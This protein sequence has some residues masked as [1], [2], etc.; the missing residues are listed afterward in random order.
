[1]EE[2]LTLGFRKVELNYRVSGEMLT[3]ISPMVA[4]G[5]IEVSSVHN[6]FPDA[7]DERFG[8]DSR[9]LGHEDPDL[10]RRAIE[11]TLR[12]AERGAELGARALVVH[13]GVVPDEGRGT[14]TGLEWDFR[15]KA[16][17]GE[18][19]R[20][21]D[22]EYDGPFEEYSALRADHVGAEFDRILRSLEE[23]ADGIVRL[24]LAISIGI[25][26]RPMCWQVPDFKEMGLILN[27]LEG[28]PLG[29]WLDTGHGALM[30]RL[31]FFDDVAEAHRLARRLVGMHIHDIEGTDDHFAPY[32]REGLDRYLALIEASPIKV[33]ELGPKNSR[34]DVK[35]GARALSR[36]LA[37]ARGNK[38]GRTDVADQG[39][40]Q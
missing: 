22:P 19:F 36:A 18:G 35:K 34:E 17:A 30:R 39:M 13:P 2:I 9:L 26:N 4:R 10:R 7:E 24:R 14:P 16:L 11:L 3:T 21:G 23:I 12:S 37:A 32:S 33:L 15:L 31:G 6:V 20:R 25:E 5:E 28:A 27:R 8:A 40:A 29:M 1:M 38:E